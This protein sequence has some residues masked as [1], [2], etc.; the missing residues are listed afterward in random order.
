[1]PEIFDHCLASLTPKDSFLWTK[2]QESNYEELRPGYFR[3][4]IS[5][6]DGNWKLEQFTKK[7]VTYFIASY[8]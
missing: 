4:E 1:M 6:S 7:Y 8:L 2:M 3:I 5:N